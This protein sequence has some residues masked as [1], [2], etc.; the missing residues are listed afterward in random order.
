[1][2]PHWFVF[3]VRCSD[4]SLYAGVTANVEN[5]LQ[6]MNGGGG[7]AWLRPRLPVFLAYTEE[8]MNEIDADRRTAA[9]KRMRRETK[10][11]LLTVPE[12]DAVGRT[13]RAGKKSR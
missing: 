4:G 1:M 10:E 2:T 7:S 11:R 12:A 6:A 5:E 3:V 9:I 13:D 8:Y